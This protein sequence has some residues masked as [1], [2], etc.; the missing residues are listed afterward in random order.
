[1]N[2]TSPALQDSNVGD[3]LVQ[4][5]QINQL[6]LHLTDYSLPEFLEVGGTSLLHL[7]TIKFRVR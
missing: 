2:R 1:M 3:Q 6:F 7:Q 5:C 4:V